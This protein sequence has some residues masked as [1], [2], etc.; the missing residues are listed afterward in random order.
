MIKTQLYQLSYG[1]YPETFLIEIG[2]TITS[3]L[4]DAHGFDE[5]MRSAAGSP[6]PLA[7]PFVIPVGPPT[8]HPENEISR[9]QRNGG[10]RFRPPPH[11][12]CYAGYA[13][14]FV[15]DSPDQPAGA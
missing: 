2:Q 6:N 15:Q 5:N 11:T 1:V 7:G 12:Q 14:T 13:R 3:K 8:L 10:E 9:G 4:A